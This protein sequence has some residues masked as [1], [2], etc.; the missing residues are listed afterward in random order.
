[1]PLTTAP[2]HVE[3]DLVHGFVEPQGEVQIG[4]VFK[5]G[6]RV[7]DDVFDCEGAVFQLPLVL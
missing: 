3:V 4:W 5:L 6:D 7:Y 1:M 2:R